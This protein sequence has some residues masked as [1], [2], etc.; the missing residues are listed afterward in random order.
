MPTH[1]PTKNIVSEPFT[2]NGII[3]IEIHP[4]VCTSIL[5]TKI[6]N[7]LLTVHYKS[8]LGVFYYKEKK[9]QKLP[10]GSAHCVGPN[11]YI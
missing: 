7:G 5:S 1:Q 2:L 6:G 3:F 4:E 11:V 9:K 10:N 8:Y